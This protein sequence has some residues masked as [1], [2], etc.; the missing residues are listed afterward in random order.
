MQC[1]VMYICKY[2]GTVTAGDDEGG[3]DVVTEDQS[4]SGTCMHNH[5]AVCSDNMYV[6]TLLHS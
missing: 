4:S 1:R 5:Y 6:H 2:T 3:D